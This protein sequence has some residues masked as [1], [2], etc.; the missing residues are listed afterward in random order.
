MFSNCLKGLTQ[1]G[2]SVKFISFYRN[3]AQIVAA[4]RMNVGRP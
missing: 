2:N 1:G 4:N 3:R